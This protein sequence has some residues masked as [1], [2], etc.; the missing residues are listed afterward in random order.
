MVVISR[1]GRG[2]PDVRYAHAKITAVTRDRKM[3]R[4][5]KR[6]RPGVAAQRHLWWPPV[7]IAFAAIL[8][9]SNS[10]SGPLIFDDRG[11]IVDNPTIEDL[12]SIEVF[13]APHETPAAG[14]PVA[15]FSFAL[16]YAQG[17]RSVTGY[18]LANIAIH[19]VAALLLFGIVR[20][21]Q[22]SATAALAIGLIWALH[23]L[24]TEA[25]DYITQ[26]T[27]LL[28]GM[29]YLLTLYSAVCA[30]GAAARGGWW[31][32]VAVVACALGMA[33]K[34]SIV[35]APIAVLLFDY[36]FLSGS[37]PESF[38]RRR[39]L[40]SGLA[41]TWLVLIALLWTTPRNLSAG[42]SAHD[43]DTWTYLLNQCVLIVR[44]LWLALWPRDLVLYYGWP[45]PLTLGEVLPQALLIVA[46]LGST[47]YALWRYP[48]VGFLG[49]WFF[50]TLAPTSSV[51]P[52]A[53]EVGAERRMYLALIA[54]VAISV[55]AF[56]RLVAAPTVRAAALVTVAL[57]CGAGTIMRNVEYRSSL[58]LAETTF[59]RWPTPAAHSMLG[60][61]LA[62]A[63]LLPE[64]ERH[65]REAAPFHP[66]ARYYLGTVLK[67]QGQAGEA[68]AQ[69]ESFIASQP[70]ELDQVHTARALLADVLLKEGR[71]GEAAIQYKAMLA[72]HPEDPSAM[73]L[74]AQVYLRE[75]RFEDAIPLLRSAAVAE[76]ANA[77]TLGSLG[78]ALGSTGRLDEAIEVFRRAVDIDPQN[79]GARQNLDRAVALRKI[80][81]RLELE[82]SPDPEAQ[83][84]RRNDRA[85][86][87]RRRQTD[88]VVG[89]EQ[90]LVRVEDVEQ[91]Q[92][93]LQLV[94]IV[95]P[96]RHALLQAKIQHLRVA[97]PRRVVETR[98]PSN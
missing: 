26:R 10:L 78:I 88:V 56:R 5:E 84:A 74:L 85:R 64:A 57:L 20:R 70:P 15:N 19:V 13:S 44:Y 60:T 18:H 82:S 47:G 28:M 89:V 12:A 17:G 37:I 34:E 73:V 14:R 7:V 53:T 43:A 1:I 23:P 63:G 66:P 27:E 68:I 58:R 90:Y 91:V 75:Q 24:N 48:R 46:L 92:H 65:L 81:T 80:Q 95:V 96:D 25:I 31:N 50:L 77:S 29:F 21:A 59:E 71:L 3:R 8:A 86:R 6:T 33:S 97:E 55:V 49:A 45:L 16:N 36:A 67:Q 32:M 35:T 52:I 40:Y 94:A 62:A 54:V 39:R 69:F 2:K 51:I 42:F 30:P 83:H 93:Q 9:Y 38:R 41:A 72:S 61:E 76:P 22:P 87:R 11:T 4:Q 79:A 98:C